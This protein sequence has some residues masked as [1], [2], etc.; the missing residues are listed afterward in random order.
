MAQCFAAAFDLG[1]FD[2]LK[3]RKK[4]DKTELTQLVGVEK[5]HK[6]ED[7]YDALVSMGILER[8]DGF[9]SNAKDVDV[10]CTLGS[11]YFMG[12][13]LYTVASQKLNNWID[14]GNRMK[15]PSSKV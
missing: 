5:F 1:I 13:L 15:N 4:L 10:Y 3:Q 12:S 2:I 9:Y 7:L 14:L 8:I 11:E 6:P